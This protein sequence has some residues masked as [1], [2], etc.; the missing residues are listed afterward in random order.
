MSFLLKHFLY[1]FLLFNLCSIVRANTPPS[2]K[3]LETYRVTITN[4]D[5]PNVVVGCD[6]LGGQVLKPGDLFSWKFRM[7]I[8]G[9]NQYN[10]RFYWFEDGNIRKFSEFP[11][12]DEIIS[13][14]CGIWLFIRNRCYWSVAQDGFYYSDK[15]ASFPGSDWSKK[16]DWNDI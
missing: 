7:N 12:F 10:C 13:H 3:Q 14:R 2:S 1:I 8:Y 16:N 9:T 6:D 11:L 15:N 4:R 5:V